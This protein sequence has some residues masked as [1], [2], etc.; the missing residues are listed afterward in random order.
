MTN[1]KYGME[2]I[3]LYV[4]D[5][6]PEEEKQAFNLQL[7]NDP[8]LKKEVEIIQKIIFGITETSEMRK[9]TRNMLNE[10]E[11][12]LPKLNESDFDLKAGPEPES[13]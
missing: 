9:V 1:G 4:L 7:E 6:M 10:Y 5:R 11:K 8:Q 13:D 2:E 3:E 12:E